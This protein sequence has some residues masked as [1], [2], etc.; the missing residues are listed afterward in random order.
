MQIIIDKSAAIR[1]MVKY[2]SKPKKSSQ[3]FIDT[4]KTVLSH[5]TDEDNPKQKLR[6]IMLKNS[7]G[8]T[9]IGQCEVCRLLMSG[10]LYQSSFQYIT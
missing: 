7:C 1:Y 5:S 2:A 9:D 3:T 4:F 8:Q 10:P 6:S